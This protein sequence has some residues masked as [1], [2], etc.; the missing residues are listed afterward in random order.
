VVDTTRRASHAVQP[1]GPAFYAA[2]T[3]E[4]AR[5]LLGCVLVRESPE[6]RTAGRIVETEGYICA[7]DPACHA[8]RRRTRRN[9]PMWG[10]PGHAYVYYTY[11]MHHMLNVVTEPEG[12]AAAVLVRALEPLEGLDL[13]AARRGV[14]TPKLLCSGPGRL[15]QAMGIDLALNTASLSGPDLSILPGEPP[16]A[17]VAT[18]RI[19]ISQGR[20]FPW[21]YYPAANPWISK[22]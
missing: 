9:E 14:G 16:G 21:R 2:P 1:L 13:M 22:K 5:N 6:G 11:G 19:G 18:T 7:V 15:C 12:E 10:P 3:L 20:D 17:V 4:V 8:Y